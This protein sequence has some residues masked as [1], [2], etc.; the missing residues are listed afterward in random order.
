MRAAEDSA[1]AGVGF[2]LWEFALR[3]RANESVAACQ[4][5]FFRHHLHLL[6][7]SGVAGLFAAECIVNFADRA[8]PR[9]PQNVK[10]LQLSF[11]GSGIAGL[12]GRGKTMRSTLVRHMSY[13][14]DYFRRSN[15]Y[16]RR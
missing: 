12:D 1:L 2:A 7:Y 13:V 10:N 4:K 5:A 9:T 15:S 6:Q 14:N 11:R 3:T 8:R 16:L